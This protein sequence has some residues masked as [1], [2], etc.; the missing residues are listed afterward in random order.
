[1]SSIHYFQRYTQRENVAT[2][3]TLLLFSRLHQ[4]SPDKF[5]KLLNELLD[6]IDMIAGVLFNQQERGILSTPDGSISQ[7]SFKLILETKMHQHFDINQL[8]AHF[9][10]FGNEQYQFLL[11][12]S[13]IPPDSKLRKQ[14]E[15]Q[16]AKYNSTKKTSIRYCSSTFREVVEK[17]RSAIT[18]YDFE[19]ADMVEDYEDYCITSDPPLITNVEDRMKI[20]PCIWTLEENFKYDLYYDLVER[21]YSPFNYLGIYRDKEVHGIG[22]V[23]NVIAAN[24]INGAL[25]IIFSDSEVTPKQK[26]N[27]HDVII[28]AQQDNNWNIERNHKFFC[29]DKFHK[30]S[31]KKETKYS[32]RRSKIF[33]LKEFLDIPILTSVEEIAI[34]LNDYKW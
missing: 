32:M 12:L 1:M 28:A 3:N 25:E 10:S 6:D 31:F 4:D 2:N 19:L 9:S 16:V 33:N 22:K 30:T 27:I 23:E 24:L 11:S 5:R 29:V 18:E 7:I 15:D 26:Q 8:V 14:I 20:V 13:P 21:G 34:K 17:F